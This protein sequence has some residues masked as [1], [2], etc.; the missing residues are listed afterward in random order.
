MASCEDFSVSK[1]ACVMAYRS[2]R[3]QTLESMVTQ[4]IFQ[5]SKHLYT[6]G[7][8]V[9]HY[10][11]QAL[12]VRMWFYVYEINIRSALGQLWAQLAV[13]EILLNVVS[14]DSNRHFEQWWSQCN[15][16]GYLTAEL[17][18]CNIV[19]LSSRSNNCTTL[20]FEIYHLWK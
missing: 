2:S 15:L 10:Q 3:L 19:T 7:I 1:Y 17:E 20:C 9:L 5:H 14:G 11:L 8:H 6:H 13:T 12:S 16:Q 4:N 18:L